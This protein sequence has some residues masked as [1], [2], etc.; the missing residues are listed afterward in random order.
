V[1]VFGLVQLEAEPLSSLQVNV[2]GLP[3]AWN[4]NVALVFPV[5]AGGVLS[6]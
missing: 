4:V 2:A 6:R 5:P 1:Y 3:L